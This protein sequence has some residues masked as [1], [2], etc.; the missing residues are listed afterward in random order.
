MENFLKLIVAAAFGGLIG[1]ERQIGGQTAG[2]RTQLLVCLGSC[3]FTITS[4]HVYKVYGAYTDPARIAAQIVVGIGFLGAGAI[5]RYGISIRG[6]TTAA[7]LWIVSAIGMAVGFG[8]YMIAMF[9]TFI[10]LVNLVVL[11]NIEDILPKNH[12][13]ILIIKTKGSEEL[14]I[15]EFINGYNIKVLDAKIKI[16]KEQNIVE[17]ELSLRY[18]DYAQLTEFLRALKNIPNLIELHIS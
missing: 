12:Y 3:L 8:E 4:I 5:L 7:T 14:K 1:I 15:A 2:F 16:M 6:L 18:K 17:Q 10:V 9:T 13:S 11:K